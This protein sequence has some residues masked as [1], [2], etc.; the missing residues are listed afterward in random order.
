M[1]QFFKSF[2]GSIVVLLV[3][4]SAA[5][6]SAQA[7]LYRVYDQLE[8]S[9]PAT[10]SNHD[11]NFITPQSVPAG[12]RISVYFPEGLSVP[13]NF[14]FGDI[15]LATAASGTIVFS[16]RNLSSSSGAWVDGVSVATGTAGGFDV[17]LSGMSG[18]AAGSQI[19]L[20][21]GSNATFGQAGIDKI[22]NAP[23][24]GSFPVQISTHNG[25]GQLLD[26]GKTF[27]VMIDPVAVTAF[28]PKVRGNGLPT[29][30]LE[31]WTVS[32]IMSLTTN[33]D[34]DCRYSVA[35]GTDWSSMTNAFFS[36]DHIYHTVLLTGLMSTM[37]YTYYV[38]CRDRGTL[39]EDDTDYVIDFY[40]AAA[41]TG[42]GGGA[43]GGTGTGSGGGSGSAVSNNV[44]SFKKYPLDQPYPPD[45]TLSGWSSPVSLIT[46]LQDDKKAG[47]ISSA[48][49]GSFMF[50][51]PDI[52]K[53][54][55]T[56]T[57]WARDSDGVKSSSYSSTFWVED[58]TQTIIS[59]ILMPPTI[60]LDSDY[61]DLGAP[62]QVRGQSMPGRKVEVH[63]YSP[64]QKKT[65]A[66]Q[67]TR[68][69]ADGRWTLS[70]PTTG[71]AK[72]VYELKARSFHDSFGWSLYGDTV[73]CGVGEQAVDESPCARSDINK[74]GKVNLVDFSIMMFYW[75]STNPTADINK[76]GKVN[77]V[78]FSIMMY[79]WTG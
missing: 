39:I 65:I 14:D 38:R 8:T 23:V 15:D 19:K 40:I 48:S 36:S 50:S 72:G 33:Y 44:G 42:T 74:D 9:H 76:D 1:R 11:I 49:D 70:V 35:S 43:G 51:V 16:D 17:F 41:G 67:E 18:I 71:Y 3:F 32:T 58:N 53:G 64:A 52:A 22:A 73:R 6:L 78:D 59:N 37:H 61:V 57:L 21:L 4:C 5:P 20:E 34:A 55:Y 30:V 56:F 63:I 26:R 77:L 54:L 25:G 75:G 2:K 31:S 46:V 69:G 60:K 45:I 62:I 27:V 66:F 7:G 47:E 28:M 24:A 12:G 68:S 79:C 29:G 10:S 13:E